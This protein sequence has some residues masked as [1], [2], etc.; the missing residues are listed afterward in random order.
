M[1]E[2]KW[3]LMIGVKMKKFLYI[4]FFASFILTACGGAAIAQ[5]TIQP[6]ATIQP[7]AAPAPTEMKI[8]APAWEAQTYV[9]EEVGFALDV[10]ATWTYTE[11]VVGERGSQVKFLSAPDISDNAVTIE[12]GVRLIIT[13]Y[14]WEPKDDLPAF[15]AV[16]KEAWA[17]NTIVSEAQVMLEGGLPSTLVTLQTPDTALVYLLAYVGETYLVISGEGDLELAKQVFLTLR[18]VTK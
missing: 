2:V 8:P 18:E 17:D 9:N 15:I 12:G 7:T 3:R 16:R 1:Q 13:L 11:Q 10:P 14:D 4:L 5:P 6:A